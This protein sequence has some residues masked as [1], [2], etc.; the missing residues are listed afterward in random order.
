MIKIGFDARQLFKDSSGL[1]NYSRSTVE[2]LTK[3][4]PDNKYYLFSAHDKNRVGFSVPKGSKIITPNG[5]VGDLLPSVWHSLTMATDIRKHRIDIFHGLANQLPSDIRMS[6][7]TSVVT[8]HDLI[9]LRYPNLYSKIEKS[10]FEW[11]YRTS[12]N[13]ADMIIAISEQ[14][15]KDLI[16]FWN[17]PP[18]RITVVYQGCNTLYL[19]EASHEV[20][21]RVRERYKLP[22]NYIVSVGTIE[23]R[24]NLMIT[25]HALHEGKLDIPLIACGRWTPYVDKLKEYITENG[26]ENQ[27]MFIHDCHLEELPAI[28]QMAT[29]SVYASLFEGF[30]IPILES[31]NSG[32]PVITSR[33]GV[34]SET[35]GDAALY[36]GQYDLEEMIEQL[37]TVLTDSDRRDEL[38]IA[39]YKH[40]AKFNDDKIA[41][42]IMAVYHKL[43]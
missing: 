3:H 12:C 39:G 18:E 23:E 32:T 2:L 25:L 19:S 33:G 26:M 28:Y 10:F 20:K 22:Q 7:A 11:K 24:K 29:V 31:M 6:G 5:V 37:K 41:D 8:I 30:G 27:V 15:K 42:D 4:H 1:G 14:T 21:Q 38:I 13:K 17:I 36:V 9:F 35:G 34:F 43:L 40:A 16:E